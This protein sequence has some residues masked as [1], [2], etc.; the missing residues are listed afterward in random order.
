MLSRFSIKMAAAPHILYSVPLIIDCL[1]L[2]CVVENIEGDFSRYLKNSKAAWGSHSL[3]LQIRVEWLVLAYIYTSI[4]WPIT[5]NSA[6]LKS[7]QKLC[8][9]YA[10][11]LID[12]NWTILTKISMFFN[13][14]LIKA[15]LRKVQINIRKSKLNESNVF[16]PGPLGWPAAKGRGD[17][18][19]R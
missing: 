17:D 14:F 3:Q 7:V 10:E 16:P 18:P 6:F 11:S 13:S 19:E 9:F 4:H 12:R 5:T 8:N 1:N 2:D 15:I